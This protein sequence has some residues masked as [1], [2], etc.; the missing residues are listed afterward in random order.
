M[1]SCSVMFVCLSSSGL[2]LFPPWSVYF[3]HVLYAQFSLLPIQKLTSFFAHSLQFLAPICLSSDL[4]AL[5]CLLWFC[6][7]WFC[8]LSLRDLFVWNL[9]PHLSPQSFNLFSYCTSFAI[10]EHVSLS[11]IISCPLFYAHWPT[12][13]LKYYV[14]NLLDWRNKSDAFILSFLE[15]SN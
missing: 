13:S 8:S 5:L 1:S 6:N 14:H 10:P 12:H 15:L 4:W 7:N 11:A 2:V 3:S 9:L